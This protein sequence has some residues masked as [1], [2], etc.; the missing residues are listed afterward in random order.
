MFP[1]ECLAMDV[2]N[3]NGSGLGRMMKLPMT[4]LGPDQPPAVLFQPLDQ[5][6]NLHFGL[7]LLM[8]TSAAICNRQSQI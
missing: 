3:G 5:I 7:A 1:R 6:A 2:G 8:E 4:S